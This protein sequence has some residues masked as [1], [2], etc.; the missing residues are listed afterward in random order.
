MSNQQR[1]FG[2]AKMTVSSQDEFFI[3]GF[4]MMR[5]LWSG[6]SGLRVHQVGMDVEGNNISNVNTY[7]FKYSRVNYSTMFSQT[8]SI[9]TQPTSNLGGKN[10]KQVGLGVE[11][12]ATQRIHSQGNLQTT[13]SNY[14]VAINGN[15]F[16]LVS[17]DGGR[18]QY[19]T[20]DGAFNQDAA[21]N[22]VNSSGYV[23]QGWV[24]DPI[25]GRI[26]T[27][28]PA[29][30]IAWDPSLTI[31]ANPSSE[32][33]LNATLNSGNKISQDTSRYIYSLDSAHGHRLLTGNAVD[34]NA[35]KAN[36]FYT[37]SSNAID[38]T[39]KAIDFAAI[40]NSDSYESLNL[41]NG[42]SFWFSYADAKFTTEQTNNLFDPNNQAQQQDVVF[43]GHSG[44]NVRLDITLNGTSIISDTINGID[45]A[46]ALIN[47]Y[48][49]KTG[50]DVSISSDKKNLIFTNRNANG[51][52]DSMKNIDLTVN[53]G[54]EAG[55]LATIE[56]GA[57]P[58]TYNNTTANGDSAWFATNQQNSEKIIT[59]HRYEYSSS[60][61]DIPQM[62][63][64]VSGQ[65]PFQVGA[66]ANANGDVASRNYAG[67]LIGALNN[68]NSRVF[69][70]TEDLRELMQ[71]DARYGVDY[72]SLGN[73]SVG[74][75]QWAQGA[76]AQAD[77]NTSN[78]NL[79]VTLEVNSTGRY[80][81][82]NPAGT[83]ILNTAQLNFQAGQTYGGL[84]LPAAPA[85][86]PTL[87]QNTQSTAEDMYF[88]AS[89]YKNEAAQ[90]STND[91]LANIFKGLQ[92]VLEAGN[93]TK[94]SASM[95]LSSFS[96]ALQ[97]YDSL[98]TEHL[99][100]VEWTK[101]ETT[102]DGGNLWQMILR[103]DEPAN[104]NTVGLARNNIIV[105]EVR[106]GNDGS[107]VSY[108]P[109]TISFTGNNGSAPNQLISLNL[110][111]VGGFNGLVSNNQTSGISQQETDGYP[112]GTILQGMQNKQID[113]GGNIVASFSNGIQ[114]VVGKIAMGNVT[115]ESGLEELG[116]NL[117]KTSANSGTLT[118]GTSATGGRGTFKSATLEMSNADLSLALT[119]LIVIQRGYQANSKTITTSDT[120]LNTLLQLKQ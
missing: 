82:T 30:N 76:G 10:A 60:I 6:V 109:T 111:A 92:G 116:S 96:S 103:I 70:S 4:A 81:F 43:W 12:T 104:F 102:V 68:T 55:E 108:D 33:Y 77:P 35:N 83:A 47:S 8:M 26:D 62:H 97:V 85:Q 80:V 53:T 106:F 34:E 3:K 44:R 50:V 24:R 61:V 36:Q 2:S 74:T 37:T 115:N 88:Q 78:I 15:G 100:R 94:Q 67:A 98:G 113:E 29:G 19:L 84:A 95:V 105:G 71:R 89:A 58:P 22:F 64:P 75:A 79:N 23:V 90:I 9:A 11:A 48:S 40:Y 99:I 14:D 117:F 54:N 27:S 114:L 41:R 107:L 69:H 65:P 31:P 51:T 66:L 118:V 86:A 13:D 112:P 17:N 63:D 25:T 110:G 49:S 45:A 16:F 42:Q 39:E 28:L 38:V 32:I 1:R 57:N 21:G 119:N 101:H 72:N 93:Q 59:A 120:M 56:L 7:G 18:T 87:A 73:S 91:A 52:E 5:S 46:A 20:R